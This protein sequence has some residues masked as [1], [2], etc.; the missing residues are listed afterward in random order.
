MSFETWSKKATRL[1]IV[2]ADLTGEAEGHQGP[3]TEFMEQY[4][5]YTISKYNQGQL[6]I[7]HRGGG[8]THIGISTRRYE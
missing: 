1:T 3:S 4:A 7:I 8:V 5:L 6:S 2:K